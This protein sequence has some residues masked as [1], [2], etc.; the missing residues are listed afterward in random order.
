MLL[1]APALAALTLAAPTLK[2]TLPCAS[3]LT[4]QQL[5]GS[6]WTSGGQVHLTGRELP[7]GTDALDTTVTAD[8]D[9]A[10]EISS[11]VPADAAVRRTL[12]VTAQDVAH[13]ELTATT[14]FK[15]TW[16]GPFIRPWN[17]DGPAIGHPGRLIL[18][19]VSGYIGEPRVLY[20]HYVLRGEQ[21]AVVRV[22]RL[23][24]PCA[25]LKRRVRQFPFKP[26]R[27]GTYSVY[28]DTTPQFSDSTFDS[29]GYNRVVVR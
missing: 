8:V 2:A 21:A 13:P 4:G 14:R 24:G 5:T 25:S 19:D 27:R 22:G 9:G 15:L 11:A 6:G 18:I 23:R 7:S 28:F 12:E 17:T 26:V 29:P 3:P 20:A 1:L 10:I 16:W